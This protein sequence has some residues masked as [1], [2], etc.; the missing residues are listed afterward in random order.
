MTKEPRK[1]IP[2]APVTQDQ[3]RFVE[4]YS[5]LKKWPSSTVVEFALE[6]LFFAQPEVCK[7]AILAH[8]D[9][10]RGALDRNLTNSTVPAPIFRRYQHQRK[11]SGVSGTKLVRVALDYLRA[12]L[13]SIEQEQAYRIVRMLGGKDNVEPGES[14]T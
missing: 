4:Q 3:Y 11:E 6:C 5:E 8:Q 9:A 14:S 1:T 12:N 2:G 10:D 13:R 7:A